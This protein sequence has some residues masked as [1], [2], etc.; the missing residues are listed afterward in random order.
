MR[1]F[2]PIF[3]F[4][5]YINDL[6]DYLLDRDLTGLSTITEG[7]T[8]KMQTREH[9]TTQCQRFRCMCDDKAYAPAWPWGHRGLTR[10]VLISFSLY[11]VEK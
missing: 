11:V 5:I 8:M 10:S 4:V 9:N 7:T 1:K 2:I 6:E 3:V